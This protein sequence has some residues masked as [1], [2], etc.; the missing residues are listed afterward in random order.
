M[1]D[2]P[3]KRSNEAYEYMLQNPNSPYRKQA[4]KIISTNPCYSYFYA[5]DVIKG[6]WPKSE[7]LILIDPH[8]SYYYAKNVIQGRF[9]K[10]EKI[11]LINY[12]SFLY[13]NY[14]LNFNH[15]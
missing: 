7:K 5:R 3:F 14:I 11:I 4:E 2:L 9:P 1:N 13:L 8:Y 15:E 10:C 12:Y 6:R